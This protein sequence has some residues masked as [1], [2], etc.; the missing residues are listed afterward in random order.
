M[1][2]QEQVTCA[3]TM[4]TMDKS[5]LYAVIQISAIIPESLVG[6]NTIPLTSYSQV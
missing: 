1:Y 6:Q 5:K 3:T 4:S 2:F